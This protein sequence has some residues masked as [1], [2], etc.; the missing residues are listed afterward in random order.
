MRADGL[1]VWGLDDYWFPRSQVKIGDRCVVLSPASGARVFAWPLMV[2]AWLIEDK[3]VDGRWIVAT[4][5]PRPERAPGTD[6]APIAPPDA[7]KKAAHNGVYTIVRTKEAKDAK[8]VWRIR[9]QP[10][11]AKFAPGARIL[12]YQYSYDQFVGV[13]FVGQDGERSTLSSFKKYV[14]TPLESEAKAALAILDKI[15]AAR[16]DRGETIDLKDA[17]EV[18]VDDVRVIL[19][20]RCVR[21][22]RPLTD[23]ESIRQGIGPVCVTK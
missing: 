15:F 22:G 3:K 1:P 17:E 7:P 6:A 20:T 21:C 14:G 4:G 9:T 13:G 8:K 19:S 2:P 18:E 16:Y 10:A 5:A 12:S 23:R 11:A